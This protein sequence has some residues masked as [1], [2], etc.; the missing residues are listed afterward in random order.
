MTPR[1]S[2]TPY[3]DEGYDGPK[4]ITVKGKRYLVETV[5]HCAFIDGSEVRCWVPMKFPD[6]SMKYLNHIVEYLDMKPQSRKRFFT[7]KDRA[8][9][10]GKKYAKETTNFY[11][12]REEHGA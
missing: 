9:I 6:G 7:E 11:V 2:D 10:W 12:T 8:S 5:I 3:R 4:H 1:F